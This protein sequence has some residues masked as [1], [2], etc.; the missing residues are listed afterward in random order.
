MALVLIVDDEEMERV[1]D[2]AILEA[3]G[4]EILYARDGLAA[5]AVCKSQDV[6][7]IVTDL[8]MPEASGLRLIRELREALADTPIIAVSGWAR[9]QLDLALRYGAD[10][11]LTKP[12]DAQEVLQTVEKCLELPVPRPSVEIYRW[13]RPYDRRG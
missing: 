12:L 9:D 10:F 13:D 7:V 4:H 6:E 3:A 11:A 8:A 1:L 5:L 2:T